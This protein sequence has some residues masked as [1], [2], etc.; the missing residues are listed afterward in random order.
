MSLKKSLRWSILFQYL[1]VTDL[2]WEY[3]VCWAGFETNGVAFRFEVSRG[4]IRGRDCSVRIVTP[5]D[6]GLDPSGIVFLSLPQRPDRLWGPPCLICNVSG[7][8]RVE[9]EGNY[10]SPS[11][12]E[13]NAW[14]R[15][16]HLPP[17][18]WMA[19]F[20]VERLIYGLYCTD[21]Y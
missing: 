8:I 13:V 11:T 9:R 14:S 6:R 20:L 2:M 1:D 3:F 17:I 21:M 7:I 12:A 15:R 4:Y 19:S 5:D 10:I 18:V 16:L